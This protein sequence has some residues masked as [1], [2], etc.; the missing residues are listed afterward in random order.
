VTHHHKRHRGLQAR[1][2]PAGCTR[3][4]TTA[5]RRRVRRLR[6]VYDRRGCSVAGRDPALADNG[7]RRAHYD[8][9]DL[10]DDGDSYS[11]SA[12]YHDNRRVRAGRGPPSRRSLR[13]AER[14]PLPVSMVG[15]P[16]PRERDYGRI[17][18]T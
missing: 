9:A 2:D 16:R 4:G 3:N 12:R 15:S 1:G 6:V 18:S 14:P 10:H 5:D 7:S 17:P 8:R 11:Y 13:Q